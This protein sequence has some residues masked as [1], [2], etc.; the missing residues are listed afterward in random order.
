MTPHTQTPAGLARRLA[1]IIYDLLL[2]F[3]VLF[4]ASIPVAMGLGI[5]YGHPLY[6]LYVIYIHAVSFLYFG[7]FWVHGG[8]TPAMKT[9]KIRLVDANGDN[10]SWKLALY[11]YLAA[12]I[13]VLVVGMGFFWSLIR[14]DKATW[15]DLISNTRLIRTERSKL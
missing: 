15:H 1:S 4:A 6:P 11:H 8:Q 3:A 10:V 5:T 7:W 12:F 14:K 2:L 9:W 13:S